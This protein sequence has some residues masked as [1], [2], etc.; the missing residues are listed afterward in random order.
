MFPRLKEPFYG[1]QGIKKC[2]D[3]RMTFFK[4]YLDAFWREQDFKVPLEQTQ[5]DKLDTWSIYER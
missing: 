2:S 1:I 4:P 5:L 3:E